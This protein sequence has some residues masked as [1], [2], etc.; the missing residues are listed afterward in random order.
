MPVPFLGNKTEAKLAPSRRAVGCHVDAVDGQ[1]SGAATTP[2]ADQRL[3]QL[4]LA[5]AGDAGDAENLAFPC[6]EG[7][8]TKRRG[9]S[10]LGRPVQRSDREKFRRIRRPLLPVD[11]AHVAAD[12]HLGKLPAALAGGRH[13]ADIAAPPKDG[14]TLGQRTDFLELVRDEQNRDTGLREP[15]QHVEQLVG[16]LRRQHRCRLVHDQQR[17]VL[18]QAADDLDALLLADRQIVDAGM[19]V[20]ADAVFGRHSAHPLG[21]IGDRFARRQGQRDVLGHGQRLEQGKMLEN[22]ADA[23][24][25]RMLRAA[26]GHRPATPF[27]SPRIGLQQAID[28]FHEG[29]LAGAVLAEKRVN[30]ALPDAEG[31]IVICG[32]VPEFLAYSDR[33]QKRGFAGLGGWPRGV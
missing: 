30:L 27:D 14:R 10:R 25:A 20:D 18:Q 11:V 3:H 16:L 17:R 33:I 23:E 12:H 13:R 9:E 7:H 19:R 5:V 6:G 21:K 2:F 4:V 1:H 8:I 31:H 24:I 32:E 26:D 29:R 15:S 22:H 28:H